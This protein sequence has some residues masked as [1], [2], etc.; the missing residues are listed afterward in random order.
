[1]RAVAPPGLARTLVFRFAGTVGVLSLILMLL[2]DFRA[3]REQDEAIGNTLAQTAARM[4]SALDQD[5]ATRA[6][7]VA[8]LSELE[9]IRR[10]TNIDEMR[11]ILD[12]VQ[13]AD[14][15][16]AWIGRTNAQGTV[17]AATGGIIEGASIADRPVFRSARRE[18]FFGDVHV[19]QLLAAFLPRSEEGTAQQLIDVSWPLMAED[20]RFLGVLAAHLSWN[21][22]EQVFDEMVQPFDRTHGIEVL[23]LS[24]DSRVLLGPADSLG[25]VLKLRALDVT[26]DAAHTVWSRDTWFD[27]QT[28]LTG[29]SNSV[30]SRFY[31]GFGWRVLVRQPESIAFAPVRRVRL[32]FLASGVLITGLFALLALFLARRI[33]QPI[34]D[35]AR[36]ANRIADGEE[37]EI[38]TD[39]HLLEVVALAYAL[40]RMIDTLTRREQALDHMETLAHRDAL[41]GLHNR[42][43]FTLHAEMAAQRAARKRGALAML[44]LD[45]DGFKP[46]NDTLGHAAG[47]ELLR[48]VAQRVGKVVREGEMLARLGGDEFVILLEG[49]PAHLPAHA[50]IV[51]ERVLH[52]FAIGYPL[53]DGPVEIGCSIGVAISADADEAPEQ[54]LQRADAAL[55]AAKR[56]GRRRI[57]FASTPA[58]AHAG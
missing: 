21:W 55:Y 20:G 18:I 49:E 12:H 11:D 10:G 40:R 37:A 44:A 53:T 7:T 22:V 17:V 29:V 45:L 43:A 38:P 35:I 23:V 15:A 19:A 50:A 25:K 2:F 36:T 47:D 1:M 57:V 48:L 28:Y 13:G 16:Y 41:T 30:P 58:A 54:L 33:G 3:T 51:A 6:R 52:C 24:R 31:S 42:R 34:E 8:F 56:S 5:L 46:I 27:G 14:H 9:P 32:E 39:S 4:R 26:N